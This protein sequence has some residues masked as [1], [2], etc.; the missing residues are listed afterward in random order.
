[1]ILCCILVVVFYTIFVL[2][3][4]P[5]CVLCGVAKI[6]NILESIGFRGSQDVRGFFARRPKRMRRT[7]ENKCKKSSHGATEQV[8]QMIIFEAKIGPKIDPGGLRKCVRT[9]V[10]HRATDLTE[11]CVLNPRRRRPED[12][13]NRF[14]SYGAGLACL[15]SAPGAPRDGLARAV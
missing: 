2:C 7:P 13:Q 9:T 15:L 8:T 5:C 14:S 12:P 3:C 1:M 10:G 6:E 4:V 11:A